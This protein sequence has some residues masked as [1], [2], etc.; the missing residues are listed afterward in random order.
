MSA[1]KCG[2]CKGYHSSIAEV[3]A[4]CQPDL[5]GHV[6][7]T[8]A[9]KEHEPLEPTV[10]QLNFIKRLRHERNLDG[11]P[12]DIR[13][14]EP[15]DRTEASA[16]IK[17]LLEAPFYGGFTAKIDIPIG[18]FTVVWPDGSWRTFRFWEAQWRDSGKPYIAIGYLAGPDNTR[19][20][21]KCGDVTPGSRAVRVWRKYHPD[22]TIREGL[23]FLLAHGAD[24]LHKAGE[25]Y[26]IKSK[27]CWR[28]NHPLSVPA[29]VHRGLGPDCAQ[30]VGVA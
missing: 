30:I 5:N 24:E 1:I 13:L 8:I 25:M 7:K 12:E 15:S 19:N 9:V 27:R 16:M 29:S 21:V 10:G 20:Y 4:C 18:R 14:A 3:K 26:A 28:C 17:R 2:K 11:L 22:S 23:E 6:S